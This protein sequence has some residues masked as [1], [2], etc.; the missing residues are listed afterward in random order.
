MGRISLLAGGGLD[1]PG[2][3]LKALA[4]GADAVYIGTAAVMALVAQ[5]IPKVTLSEPSTQLVLYTGRM[6]DKFD[7]DLGTASLVNFLGVSMMEIESVMYAIGKPAVA[8]LDRKDLCCL[9]PWLARALDVAYAGVT[10]D[11]QETYYHYPN[12]APWRQ[13]EQ[14]Q[15]SSQKYLEEVLIPPL[16][17]ESS[18]CLPGPTFH[19][20]QYL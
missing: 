19:L 20:T 1:T 5:Q 10:P 2:H 8:D 15:V 6:K 9:D 3:F 7:I 18:A 13:A 17:Q 14:A 16:N 11:E 12:I 4:L